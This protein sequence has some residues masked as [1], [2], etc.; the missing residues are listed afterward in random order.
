MQLEIWRS[1]YCEMRSAFISESLQENQGGLF[2]FALWREHQHHAKASASG[3]R[4]QGAGCHCAPVLML[5]IPMSP[6][7]WWD[8]SCLPPPCIPCA[9]PTPGAVWPPL[10]QIHSTVLP[11]WG[12]PEE[13]SLSQPERL[14]DSM[15]R[16]RMVWFSP[17][18]RGKDEVPSAR[19][20]YEQVLPSVRS[21][22]LT[23]DCSQKNDSLGGSDVNKC[24]HC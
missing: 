9:L 5:P 17:Q 13:L 8:D 6:C 2:L 16:R 7:R 4:Q 21:G 12:F 18:N 22:C 20:Q 24:M 23:F 1:N 15:C 11:I 10:A 14:H 3:R 19:S